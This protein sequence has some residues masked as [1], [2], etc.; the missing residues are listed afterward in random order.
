[1]IAGFVYDSDDAVEVF[2]GYTVDLEA[3][4]FWFDSGDHKEDET[5]FLEAEAVRG[6]DEIIGFYNDACFVCLRGVM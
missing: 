2:D 3:F 6:L 1:M 4:V 5:L